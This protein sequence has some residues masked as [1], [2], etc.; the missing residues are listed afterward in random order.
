MLGT[1]LTGWDKR[2]LDGLMAG[3]HLNELYLSPGVHQLATVLKTLG[4]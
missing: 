2:D 1:T 3:F 4:G